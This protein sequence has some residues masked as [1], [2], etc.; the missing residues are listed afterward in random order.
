MVAADGVGHLP[1]YC[2]AEE[3][4]DGEAPSTIELVV[5]K[6]DILNWMEHSTYTSHHR[7]SHS[8]SIEIQFLENNLLN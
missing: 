6:R 5:T 1:A 3:G 4:G 7:P 2:A 8:L